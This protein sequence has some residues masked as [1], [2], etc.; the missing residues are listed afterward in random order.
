LTSALLKRPALLLTFCMST[1]VAFAGTISVPFPTAGDAYHSATNGDGTIPVGGQT[2]YQWS[3]GD[4]V[5]SPVFVASASSV[6]G[7]TENWTYWRNLGLGGTETWNIYINT[8]LVGSEVLPD[9]GVCDS[10]STLSNS[11]SFAG[12][13]PVG[14]GYQI[15]LILQ[16]TVPGGEGS[17]AWL[18]GGSTTLST[19]DSAIPEPGTMALLGLGLI[20]VGFIRRR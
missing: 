8:I 14:G 19:S 3:T 7:L 11:F 20:G 1:C 9:C 10:T 5:A 12:I 15:Q 18:D 4:W 13:A 16:N 2:A 17:V 6:T